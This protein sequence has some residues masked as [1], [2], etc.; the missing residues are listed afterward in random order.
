MRRAIFAIFALALGCDGEMPSD[1]DA[2]SRFDAGPREDAWVRPDARRDAGD[3]TCDAGSTLGDFC[4]A[5]GDCNDLCFCNGSERCQGGVCVSGRAACDD[6]LACTTDA[7]DEA[8]LECD[9]EPDDSACDDADPCTGEEICDVEVGCL[10]GL[11]MNCSD[12]ISCTI[13]SCDPELLCRNILRDLDHD[14]FAD[15][16]CEG[17]VDCDDDP[18]TGA[19]VHPGATEVCD[20]SV[21][22][23]CN[24]VAD[25]FDSDAC[26][27][28][29]DACADA[30]RIAGSGT[31][32]FSTEGLSDDYTLSCE[33]TSGSRPDA[34]FRF[35]TIAARDVTIE[36]VGS[37]TDSTLAL[38]PLADCASVRTLSVAC[39]RDTSFSDP[40]RI[41]A[42]ALEAGEYAIV[43]AV[44]SEG[45]H[46][47]EL[48]I[49]APATTPDNDVCD[50]RTTTITA[51]ESFS[52]DFAL[53][54]DDYADV[55]CGERL[56]AERE[57]AYRLSLIAPMDVHIEATAVN[58]VGTPRQL[59]VAVVNEC[60]DPIATRLGCAESDAATAAELDLPALPAGEYWILVEHDD[61]TGTAMT[62][63]LSVDITPPPP[64][65]MADRCDSA[66]DATDRT[67]TIP[68][69][70]LRNDGGL[71]CGGSG[72]MYRDAF[73]S[74]DVS[75]PSDVTITTS[76][77]VFHLF[78]VTPDCASPGA[79]LVCQTSS[80]GGT[81]TT[82]LSGLAPGTYWVG[83][84]IAT[85]TGDLSVTT[86]VSPL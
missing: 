15:G 26:A 32:D 80:P 19:S 71:G 4:R 39:D 59:A 2:G 84:A 74:F 21:D 45:L 10:P 30:T 57:A 40:A 47:F 44:P 34:I 16:R 63:D 81:G 86:A 78:S 42:R 27:P 37:D 7:C 29:N 55:G 56:T 38:V 53:L 72:M 67:I 17:G 61:V 33:S 54:T 12:G 65:S 24:G 73:F 9:R 51:T 64:P 22:D 69:A 77:P 60:P 8:R 1:P 50:A 43:I 62:Y 66:A 28:T 49:E 18:I 75:A 13:D 36:V 79:E 11:P 82:T 31:Y 83:V 58:E 14:G 3:E 23:D 48:T 20:N 25:V 52:G 76:A 68:I 35:T 6:G 41:E 46:A 85:D 5:D 70:P